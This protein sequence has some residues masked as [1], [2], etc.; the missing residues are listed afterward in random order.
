MDC[1]RNFHTWQ[2]FWIQKK[3]RRHGCVTN[4][5]H[6]NF[7]RGKGRKKHDAA[8]WS[9]ERWRPERW[10]SRFSPVVKPCPEGWGA[11]RWG[12]RSVGS[13]KF[14][15]FL[16][17]SCHNVLSFFPLLGSSRGILVF[18]ALDP[19]M[20]TF[21]VL[22]LSCA[23]ASHDSPRAQ[24]WTFEGP[25]LQNTTQIA[26]MWAVRR[27]E[28]GPPRE[29]RKEKK[30]RKNKNKRGKRRRTH[31]NNNNWFRTLKHQFLSLLVN[32]A[33]M[34]NLANVRLAKL[35][36]GQTWFDQTWFWPKLVC[37]NW[38]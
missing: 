6:T 19:E 1:S 34:V 8:R 14:R 29:K 25:G 33:T 32:L 7:G 21:Q 26:K 30:K 12:P 4:F 38:P 11:E 24:T 16:T 37:Q 9:P 3:T 17:L 35:G 27:R 31:R 18:E 13:P 28:G 15:V 20:F 22:G 10:I 5:G 2:F 36:T 23:G